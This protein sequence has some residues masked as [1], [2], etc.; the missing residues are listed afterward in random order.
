MAV[1]LL[2]DDPDTP[3]DG[4]LDGVTWILDAPSLDILADGL[5][6][7]AAVTLRLED[8]TV[9]GSAGCNHYGG[10][11]QLDGDA[12]AFEGFALTQMACDEPLMALDQAYLAALSSVDGYQVSG[13]ALV[14]TGA[15]VAL[16]YAA[17]AQAP[18]VGTAWILD[19]IASG[20]AVSSVSVAADLTFADD[21]AVSGSGGCNRFN[22]SYETDGSSL[23]FSP[24]AT[25]RMACED[26]VM[27]EELAVLA[28]LEA[29][30]SYSID[31]STLSLLD[32]SG[33]LIL[34]YRA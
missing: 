6:P 15:N 24:L 17:E 31:G 30:A 26:V 18:L 22:G 32:A 4:G 25:T 33:Q 20:D 9:G 5:P 29:T 23:S 16:S 10:S 2:A 28:G 13:D 27:V 14:L 8:G 12:I 3:D 34:G 21:G 19:S 7:G 11:Y 1:N